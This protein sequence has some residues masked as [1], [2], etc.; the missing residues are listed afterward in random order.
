EQPP[1]PEPVANEIMQ[2]PV[3]YGGSQVRLLAQ[4]VEPRQLLAY[5][6]AAGVRREQ[7]GHLV[8][9]SLHQP[10]PGE[11]SR[12]IGLLGHR[13]G[14]ARTEGVQYLDLCLGPATG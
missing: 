11:R 13:L 3:E 10:K 12:R 2:C 4:Q 6:E 5:F 14:G 9:P 7:V 8:E 1:C